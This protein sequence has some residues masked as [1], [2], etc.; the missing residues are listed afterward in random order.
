MISFYSDGMLPGVYWLIVLRWYRRR[1]RR[2]AATLWWGSAGGARVSSRTTRAKRP[3]SSSALVHA[4]AAVVWGSRGRQ[5]WEVDTLCAVEHV[6]LVRELSC[7]F[8][9]IENMIHI[10]SQVYR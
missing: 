9:E 1:R 4:A 8:Y 2:A 6:K 10:D 3:G 7:A 5:M